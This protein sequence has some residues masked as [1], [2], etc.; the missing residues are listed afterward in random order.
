MLAALMAGSQVN[1]KITNYS[2]SNTFLMIKQFCSLVLQISSDFLPKN[3]LLK[4]LITFFE[5]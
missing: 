1:F 2:K 4:K 5:T 3:I